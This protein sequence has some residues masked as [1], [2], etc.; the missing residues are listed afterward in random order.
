MKRQKPKMRMVQFSNKNRGP[1][2][3]QGEKE[4]AKRRM[5]IASQSGKTLDPKLA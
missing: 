3:E 4:A 1:G 5:V 2:R